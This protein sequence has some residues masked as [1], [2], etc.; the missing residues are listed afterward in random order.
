MDLSLEGLVPS[1]RTLLKSAALSLFAFQ[2]AGCR[3]M[4]TPG[5]AQRRGAALQVLTSEEASS[6]EAF[7]EVLVPGA[8][9]AGV[10]H[11]VDANLSRSIGDSLLTVRYLDVLPPHDVFYKDGLRALDAAASELAGRPF[12][13]LTAAE[14]RPLVAALLPAKVAG[15]TGPPSPLFY[16][17]VRSDAADLVYGTRAAFERMNIPYMAHIEPPTDW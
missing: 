15:W 4:L 8:R 11:Y 17:A 1:R 5:E 2:V 13:A 12:A 10:A 9:E 7:G 14:A 16:L 6:L 3:E